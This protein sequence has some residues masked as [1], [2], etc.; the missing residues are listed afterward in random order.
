MIWI[1]KYDTRKYFENTYRESG[2]SEITETLWVKVTPEPM[3]A[4]ERFFNRKLIIIYM[5]SV[6]CSSMT[7]VGV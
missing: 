4:L 6:L 2:S 7:K 3:K 1:G 5:S